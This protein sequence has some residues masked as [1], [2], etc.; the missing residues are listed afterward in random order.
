MFEML[1]TDKDGAI[2]AAEFGAHA[3][4]RFAKMDADG[5]TCH[6]QMTAAREAMRTKW[7]E[8]RAG[9]AEERFAA[10]DADDDGKVTLQEMK[11]AVAKRMAEHKKDGAE[12]RGERH[13]ER[14]KALQRHGRRWRWRPDAGG[15]AD[16]Q[17]PPASRRARRRQAGRQGA[18]RPPRPSRHRWRRPYLEGRVP[19]RQPE[20]VRTHGQER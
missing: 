13:A 20:N 17:E 11:D 3:E 19:G 5:D 6:Q 7:R 4:G 1:D 2:T 10:L 8:R 15:N 14:L 12:K 18:R 9:T 16:G